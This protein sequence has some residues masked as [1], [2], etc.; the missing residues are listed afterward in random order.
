MSR[1]TSAGGVGA[2][3]GF[4][5]DLAALLARDHVGLR[6]VGQPTLGPQHLMQAIAALAAKDAD[7]E[8]ERHEV[9]VVPRNADVP[10]ADFGLH[11]IGLVDDDH[12]PRRARRLDELLARHLAPTASA[13]KTLPTPCRTLPRQ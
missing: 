2:R 6:A 7:R 8:I 1:S 12:A 13:P 11:R 5:R 3:V 9:G 10:D 4:R